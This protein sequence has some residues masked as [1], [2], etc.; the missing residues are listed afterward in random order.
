MLLML[1][2]CRLGL[3]RAVWSQV[4]VC[5]TKALLHL[6]LVAYVLKIITFCRTCCQT[7]IQIQVC[8]C[9]RV[10]VE[11]IEAT[12]YVCTSEVDGHRRFQ[13]TP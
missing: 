2:L 3:R 12:D 9:L 8:V 4:K 7:S 5:D 6:R 11:S 10:A 13:S 1:K